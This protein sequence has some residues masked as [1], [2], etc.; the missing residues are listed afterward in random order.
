MTNHRDRFDPYPFNKREEIFV[1]L[2][3]SPS[4]SLAR[5]MEA[6]C[7]RFSLFREIDCTVLSSA[8][9]RIVNP[10]SRGVVSSTCVAVVKYDKG[11]PSTSRNN[12]AKPSTTRTGYC[13][14]WACLN[15]EFL[16][17]NVVAGLCIEFLSLMKSYRFAGR[18]Q[19]STTGSR[20]GV[21]SALLFFGYV[22]LR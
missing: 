14:S 13:I 17:K 22:S 7:S 12:S 1:F 11:R 8:S 3:S 5:E 2:I 9:A 21:Q 18:L 19:T 4:L 15:L 16:L 6:V 20:A 10:S